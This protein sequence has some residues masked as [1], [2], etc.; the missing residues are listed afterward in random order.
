[1]LAHV[2]CHKSM[3][4]R[5]C[6]IDDVV[7][8]REEGER[9]KQRQKEEAARLRAEKEEARRAEERKRQEDQARLKRVST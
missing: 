9:A 2:S 5:S 7:Q 4:L 8:A 1:M 6:V 3:K